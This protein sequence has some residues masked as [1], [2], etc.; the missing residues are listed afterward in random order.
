V[1]PTAKNQGSGTIA[2]A[3]V[4]RATPT[5]IA[6]I[7]RVIAA[8]DRVLQVYSKMKTLASV[9]KGVSGSILVPV[10]RG[11]ASWGGVV[12]LVVVVMGG[13]DWGSIVQR[14]EGEKR[15]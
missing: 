10:S 7:L 3:K 8:C 2:D 15:G 6:T 5:K 11:W 1:L 4:A 12:I 14:L 13:Y 9:G